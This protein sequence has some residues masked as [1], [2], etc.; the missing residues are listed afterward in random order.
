MHLSILDINF[1]T[2]NTH[3]EVTI[4]NYHSIKHRLYCTVFTITLTNSKHTINK[5]CKYKWGF[6]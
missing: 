3:L 6:Y 1:G 5:W 2:P 4:G